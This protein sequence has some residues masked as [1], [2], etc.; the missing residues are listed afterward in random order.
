MFRT[1]KEKKDKSIQIYLTLL[2]PLY[3]PEFVVVCCP[4]PGSTP[5][6]AL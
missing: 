4:K 5:G 6:A 3:V 1:T 2:N